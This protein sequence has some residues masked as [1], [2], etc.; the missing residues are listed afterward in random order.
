MAH[1]ESVIRCKYIN[2]FNVYENNGM[3]IDGGSNTLSNVSSNSVILN[4]YDLLQVNAE[5]DYVITDANGNSL[6]VIDGNISGTMNVYR[7]TFLPTSPDSPPYYF[8]VVPRSSSYTC[9]ASDDSLQY[10]YI[11]NS[12]GTVGA[13]Y[14]DVV[15]QKLSSVELNQTGTVQLNLQNNI[16]IV[17]GSVK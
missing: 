13:S 16:D 14:L 15:N 7:W 9:V 4:S 11:T 10:F 12:S 6:S 17:G 8:F 3:D 2:D 5:N 1:S